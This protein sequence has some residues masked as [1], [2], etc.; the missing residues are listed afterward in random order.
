MSKRLAAAFLVWAAT[1]AHPEA[2]TVPSADGVP[3]AYEVH[4]KGTRALVLVHGWSCDRSYWKPQVDYLGAQ[5]RVVL[6]DLAGHGESGQG[7][8]DYSMPSFG[9]DVA[10]VVE[11]LALEDVVL[12]GHSM[13]GDVIVD[14]ARLLPGRVTGLVLVDTYKSLGEPQDP[15]AIDAFIDRFRRDFR[16]TTEKFVRGMF[17]A[18]ASPDLVDR[19]A[20]DMASAPPR[21]ALSAMEHSFANAARIPGLLSGLKLP[22]FAINDDREPTDYAAL[23]RHGVKA[24]VMPG[25]GHFLMEED[26][27]RFNRTLDSIIGRLAP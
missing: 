7:R 25:S 9:A 15:Q 13:G 8:K 5:Y 26:S 22:A 11:A 18:T 21:V 12:V 4:G 27:E 16:G 10:A 14:A 23:A 17:G 6:V 24:V 19:I 1:L 2:A 20:K 3:I